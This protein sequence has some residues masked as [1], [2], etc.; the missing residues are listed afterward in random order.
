MTIVGVFV[1]NNNNWIQRGYVIYGEN[2]E[3]KS[4]IA[5]ALS[6]DGINFWW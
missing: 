3:D 4:G 1:F 2:S 5:V 6:L